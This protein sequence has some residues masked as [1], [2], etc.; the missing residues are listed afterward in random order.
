MKIETTIKI[1]DGDKVY[2]ISSKE[3]EIS[4]ENAFCFLG[5]RIVEQ[6]MIHPSKK[7]RYDWL[8]KTI[9]DPI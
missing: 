7:E 6:F 9:W 5:F 1:T 8:G 4:K 2:F 3:K